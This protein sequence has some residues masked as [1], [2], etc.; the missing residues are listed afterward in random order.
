MIVNNCVITVFKAS[1]LFI[2]YLRK[3]FKLLGVWINGQKYRDVHTFCSG[4][5]C[6][7]DSV[8][9][10]GIL[11]LETFFLR[12]SS[13]E[14]A[15]VNCLRYSWF[16]V[17]VSCLKWAPTQE[18]RGRTAAKPTQPNREW[19]RVEGRIFSNLVDAWFC[20]IVNTKTAEDFLQWST[21]L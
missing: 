13:L 1:K 18:P 20:E 5:L 11:L 17:R 8:F 6:V 7:H 15:V 3:T 21:Y 12:C 9:T 14:D 10:W 2:S 4:P 16:F 19:R